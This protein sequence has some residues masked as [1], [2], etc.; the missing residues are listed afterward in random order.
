V[1]SNDVVPTLEQMVKEQ[2]A[3]SDD[4]ATARAEQKIENLTMIAALNQIARILDRVSQG[5]ESFSVATDG[6]SLSV[7]VGNTAANPVPV[8]T[9]P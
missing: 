2:Q 6:N 8:D 1:Q 3:A 4:A 9:T 7:T 5:G